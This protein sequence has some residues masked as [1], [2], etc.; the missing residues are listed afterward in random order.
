MAKELR[1]SSPTTTRYETEAV[2]EHSLASESVL[3]HPGLPMRPFVTLGAL[4]LIAIV[5]AYVRLAMR[6]ETLE[7]ELSG[8]T[9]PLTAG[10]TSAPPHVVVAPPVIPRAELSEL[11]KS[12]IAL[13]SSRSK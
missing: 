6:V 1:G 4:A 10:A 12:T 13:F 8:R 5:L 2:R 3:G 11:E 9:P 7:A